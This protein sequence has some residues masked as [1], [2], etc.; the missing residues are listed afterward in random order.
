MN[1]QAL[2]KCRPEISR[3]LSLLGLDPAT[4][5]QPWQG[6]IDNS[7]G[8]ARFHTK[9]RMRVE[10]GL[11]RKMSAARVAYVLRYGAIPPVIAYAVLGL[12]SIVSIP[13]TWLHHEAQTYAPVC[14]GTGGRSTPAMIR[15]R[16]YKTPAPSAQDFES[17]VSAVFADHPNK[18]L[19]TYAYLWSQAYDKMI[20]RFFSKA[21]TT[22]NE[23]DN[24]MVETFRR[25]VDG[26]QLKIIK[27]VGERYEGNMALVRVHDRKDVL[28]LPNID[29]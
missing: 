9:R 14:R 13:I 16:R 5:C 29:E 4:G 10:F 25:M 7:E 26:G 3:F 27:I 17:A 12:Q 11:A 15:R 24:T 2:L 23:T 20:A 8:C 1:E 21:K 22:K 18:E 28:D 19:L 6:K